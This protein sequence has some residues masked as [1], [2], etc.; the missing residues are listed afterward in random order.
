MFRYLLQFRTRQ[1]QCHQTQLL[2]SQYFGWDGVSWSMTV[3]NLQR[4]T[5]FPETTLVLQCIAQEEAVGWNG[6]L[7]REPCATAL[8]QEAA[9]VFTV[10]LEASVRRGRFL[11][12]WCP[13]GCPVFPK[14]CCSNIIMWC[15]LC[16]AQDSIVW[17]HNVVH[18]LSSP[19]Y[20]NL[21][22][23]AGAVPG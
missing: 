18:A 2:N 16:C 17:F 10:F 1:C 19:L 7:F 6:L 14:K 3:E 11:A 21:C 8:W 23:C 9:F 12:V 20:L 5:A 22:E 13:T 15:S 4:K